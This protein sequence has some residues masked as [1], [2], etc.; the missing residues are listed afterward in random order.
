M[1]FSADRR[2]EQVVTYLRIRKRVWAFGA[3][4][5]LAIAL[6]ACATA[7]PP[8]PP[9][10]PTPPP[11]PP[12]ETVAPEPEPV[13]ETWMGPRPKAAPTLAVGADELPPPVNEQGEV[14]EQAELDL[15][16]P[17]AMETL[18]SGLMAR[19]GLSAPVW[20]ET[21]AGQAQS[22]ATQFKLAQGPYS[23][24]ERSYSVN[25]SARGE[26]VHI[27]APRYTTSGLKTQDGVSARDVVLEWAAENVGA[28]DPQNRRMVQMG[29]ARAVC[30]TN[31]E[32]WVCTFD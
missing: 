25:Y 21:L 2:S 23:Y 29:C 27:S 8:A 22:M 3:L 11:P 18:H 6:T 31:T 32:I 1:M 15:N 26:A 24:C 7:P 5:G 9:P 19:R 30:P 13:Y 28:F 14:L 17:R 12:V 4:T 20:S 10:E 16:H